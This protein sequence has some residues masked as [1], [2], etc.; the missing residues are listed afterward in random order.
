MFYLRLFG[1]PH[2]ESDDRAIDPRATQRH[3]QALL[4]LLALA[5]G[6]R[7]S[8][9]KLIAYLW[10]DRD[11][12]GGRNLLKVSTYVLRSVLGDG[13]LLSEGDD[14]RLNA[15][16]LQI[17]VVEF[18]AA[19]DRCDFA[20][21]VALYRGPFLDGFFLPNAQ[22]FDSW[23]DGERAR[24][25]GRYRS[26]LESLAEAAESANDPHRVVESWKTLAAHE[27]YD[28]GVAL[29][30]MRALAAVGNRA[31]ALSTRRCT[32]ACCGKNS[33]SHS[34]RISCC[35]STS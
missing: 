10:P 9:D 19:L 6:R 34:R 1:A 27:P 7:L 15:E 26:A 13:A 20:G 22:E 2:L 31:G 17:D 25:A 21:A 32:S 35:S 8:R 23:A 14:L 28:S 4:A 3:R 16:A 24:L 12:D 33:T 18:G 29:R 5:P 30:L 11:A